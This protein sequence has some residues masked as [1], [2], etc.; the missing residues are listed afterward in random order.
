[1]IAKH[2]QGG[3]SHLGRA[4]V[5]MGSRAQGPPRLRWV[6]LLSQLHG[7]PIRSKASAAAG[8]GIERFPMACILE[9]DGAN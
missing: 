4:N 8:R 5:L 9:P 2:Y 3:L 6:A 7:T 1:M